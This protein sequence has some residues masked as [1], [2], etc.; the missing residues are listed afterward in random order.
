MSDAI[1]EKVQEAF[2]EALGVDDDEVTPEASIFDDLGAE[3]LDL[4]EIV[5]LLERAFD[6]KIPRGGV[7]EASKSGINPED[8]EQD[9][10]L[11]QLAL[12]QLKAHMPEVPEEEFTLGLTANDIPRLFRV[13]TFVHIVERLLAEKA[14]EA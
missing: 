6:I 4:L 1:F 9:G 8:Y 7:E 5:F 10:V 12:D 13:Q 3:S 11:T 14:G 2:V